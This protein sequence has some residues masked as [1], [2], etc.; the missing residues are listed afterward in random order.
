MRMCT[1]LHVRKV[2]QAIPPG[3]SVRALL[4][5]AL[6]HSWDVNSIAALE[7]FLTVILERL[8]PGQRARLSPFA[9]PSQR[10]CLWARLHI[11]LLISPSRISILT[12]STLDY[13][14]L[15]LPIAFVFLARASIAEPSPT[16]LSPSNIMSCLPLFPS[17]PLS[18]YSISPLPPYPE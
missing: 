14:H 5:G 16:I 10:A 7:G 3:G 4:D 17:L 6:V 12:A 18:P 11:Y 9:C 8:S 1:K 13:L 15:Y 2:L